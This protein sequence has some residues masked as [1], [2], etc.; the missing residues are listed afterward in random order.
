MTRRIA[1]VEAAQA[2][3]AN[4]KVVWIPETGHDIGYEKP[5]AL[6]DAHSEFLS[7]IQRALMD[8]HRSISHSF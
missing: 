1:N 4:S 7:G 8:Q 2:I 6:A 3:I 5:N